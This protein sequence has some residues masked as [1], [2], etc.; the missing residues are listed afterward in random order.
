MQ[1]GNKT[2]VAISEAGGG[3][4]PGR[5]IQTR[6]ER[7]GDRYVLSGTKIVDHRRRPLRL[8]RGVRAHRAE[9]RP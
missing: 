6:A 1:N 9:Q 4:D 7:R 3:S 2:F 5:A 8:G